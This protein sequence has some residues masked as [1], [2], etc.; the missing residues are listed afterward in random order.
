MAEAS[1]VAQDRPVF[2]PSTANLV[3]DACTMLA[4]HGRDDLAHQ[5][6][7]VRTKPLAPRTVVVIGEV[8]RGK[9]ALVN[10]LVGQVDLAPVGIGLTTAAHVRF[11]PPT[12]D[13]PEGTVRLVYPAETHA[14]RYQQIALEELADWVTLKG[15]KVTDPKVDRL[16]IAAEISISARHL[17]GVTVV[18]TPGVNGLIP[19]HVESAIAAIQGASVLL[20]VCDATA[21]INAPELNFL[22]GVSG[23]IGSVV[24]AVNKTD[25]AVQDWPLIVEENRQILRA[26]APRFANIDIVGVSSLYAEAAMSTVDPARST[27]AWRDSGVPDLADRLLRP[28]S[29]V[30]RIRELNTLTA[31][32]T[33]IEDVT[34]HVAMERAAVE[35][36]P[37]LVAHMSEEGARLNGLKSRDKEWSLRLGPELENAAIANAKHLRRELRRLNDIWDKQIDDQNFVKLARNPQQVIGKMTADIEALIR[38]VGEDYRV[39]IERI[40]TEMFGEAQIRIGM[41]DNAFRTLD[42]FK[43]PAQDTFSPWKNIFD[44]SIVSNVFAGSSPFRSLVLPGVELLVGPAWGVLAAGF[45]ATRAGKQNMREWLKKALTQVQEDLDHSVRLVQNDASTQ[46]RIAYQTLLVDSIAE[47]EALVQQAETEAQR[48]RD[49]RQAKL[50]EID[51]RSRELTSLT[52]NLASGMSRLTCS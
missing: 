38:S 52:K 41:L 13:M 34:V 47:T 33:A 42:E 25:Q 51:S 12:K 22:R 19:S 44:L 30:E 36:A 3:E 26:N 46:L 2:D 40:A 20:M 11:V 4:T 9:S 17:P 21:A 5:L 32:L 27:K 39:S 1:P 43:M 14:D 48:S 50:D 37:Q 6:R 24:L 18:D 28:L 31:A 29:D 8:N 45:Q 49:E 23:E 35:N 7:R 15:S 10:A 16:P